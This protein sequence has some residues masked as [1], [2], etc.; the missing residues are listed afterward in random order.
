MSW[1]TSLLVKSEDLGLFINTL[2]AHH[3]YYR[4]IREKFRKPIQM[5]LSNK[6]KTFCEHFIAFLKST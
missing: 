4:H 5:Q 3:K 6:A 2:I 1:N